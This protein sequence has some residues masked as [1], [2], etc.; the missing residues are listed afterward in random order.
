MILVWNEID[1]K[2][3]FW[4]Q[5]IFR[6]TSASQGPLFLFR[7]NYSNFHFKVHFKCH[8]TFITYN[9]LL[10]F[11]PFARHLIP[12]SMSFLQ[13]LNVPDYILS[14]IKIYAISNDSNTHTQY[15]LSSFNSTFLFYFIFL[16]FFFF[17][18][19][20]RRF[21]CQ[22][23]LRHFFTC[24]LYLINDWLW[25]QLIFC[26]IC[27]I[28]LNIVFNSIH[29]WICSTLLYGETKRKII[30]RERETKNISPNQFNNTFRVLTFHNSIHLTF[31]GFSFV[32]RLWK[33][34]VYPFIRSVFVSFIDNIHTFTH[35]YK[36]Q[37]N[38][39]HLIKSIC[40]AFF[41]NQKKKN[42]QT[43]NTT[44]DK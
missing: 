20:C 42:Y 12:L 36:I 6:V 8:I 25:Q 11:M 31:N 29:A 14:C 40:L 10:Y 15:T 28:H 22:Q 18:L 35:R 13:W 34:K 1:F 41:G 27:T 26:D 4:I 44:E 32:R 7:L 5:V 9:H 19:M 3:F 37:Y 2:M 30:K 24:L 16:C 38:N 39:W 33:S 23:P 17:F 43:S 21:C